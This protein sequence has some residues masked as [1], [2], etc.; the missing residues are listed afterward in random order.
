MEYIAPLI[1]TILWVFLI[2]GILYRYNKPIYGILVALQKRIESGSDIKA[3]PFELTDQLKPQDPSQQNKKSA[4][5]INDLL[6]PR[7]ISNSSLRKTIITRDASAVQNK[8]FQAEDLVLRAIQS[9]YGI[10]VSRH[11]TAG[12]DIGFDGVFSINGQLNIIEVKYAHDANNV[13]HYRNTLEHISTSIIR[14]HWKR[15]QILLA[16]VYDNFDDIAK[17][18]RRLEDIARDMPIPVIVRYYLFS[19]LKSKFSIEK[20]SENNKE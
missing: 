17:S 7:A 1:E 20:K 5:E 2:I 18:F 10:P 11:V 4:I 6:E 8:Y 9:E 12:E 16:V 3:G 14:Y 19:D 15:V 13:S